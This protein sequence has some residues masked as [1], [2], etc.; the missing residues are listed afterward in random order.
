MV[1]DAEPSPSHDQRRVLL[2]DAPAS[3]P[4]QSEAP[5]VKPQNNKVKPPKFDPTRPPPPIDRSRI[6]CRS[7]EAVK[8]QLPN[9]QTAPK[10]A[11]NNNPVA[12]TNSANGRLTQTS[13]QKE[14]LQ[15]F[16][17]H[18]AKAK[19]KDTQVDK[20]A[21]KSSNAQQ[22][23][24]LPAENLKRNT[25]QS[26]ANQ[27][28]G[29]NT[30]TLSNTPT[31]TQ[32]SRGS[33]LRQR[34]EC[35]EFVT[36]S[37]SPQLPTPEKRK[38]ELEYKRPPSI[39]WASGYANHGQLP[40]QDVRNRGY[41][42]D[43]NQSKRTKIDRSSLDKNHQ[44]GNW[45]NRQPSA[46]QDYSKPPTYSQSNQE[47]GW[48]RLQ[49]ESEWPR[50]QKVESCIPQEE[51][52]SIEAQHSPQPSTNVTL[53]KS[54][55]DAY[56]QIFQHHH[57]SQQ[58]KPSQPVVRHNRTAILGDHPANDFRPSN[59]HSEFIGPVKPE[60]AAFKNEP[61]S[62]ELWVQPTTENYGEFSIKL[63]E[64]D[65]TKQ[66]TPKMSHSRSTPLLPSSKVRCFSNA[67]II[68]YHIIIKFMSF[69]QICITMQ[70]KCI[71]QNL[72]EL[73]WDL[74][75]PGVWAK[76]DLCAAA[77][78]PFFHCNNIWHKVTAEIGIKLNACQKNG[79]ANLYCALHKFM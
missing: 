17:P 26:S 9:A 43:E 32:V 53:Y 71:I 29:E 13:N 39:K 44:E 34:S 28:S 20:M 72:F 46:F 14:S 56:N 62:P 69:L 79:D 75:K 12:R 27:P 2:G 40:S 11:V 6:F 54:Q 64:E 22:T 18:S 59:G 48:P 42:E 65:D 5:V 23:T 4:V 73:G 78:E 55:P 37:V 51:D 66:S 68:I 38:T 31:S 50:N 63:P 36:R 7:V 67:L 57:S 60:I 16:Q 24:Q 3:S 1:W 52:W 45:R 25:A 76:Y 21:T 35:Q 47:Q 61:V 15:C 10:Q 41:F 30:P 58:S 33:S 19:E 74:K 77:T 70:F 8:R 49:Y